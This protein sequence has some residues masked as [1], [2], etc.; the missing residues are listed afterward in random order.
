MCELTL[1]LKAFSP[2]LS[3]TLIRETGIHLFPC[4]TQESPLPHAHSPRIPTSEINS[5]L[6]FRNPIHSIHPSIHPSTY[7]Y[8]KLPMSYFVSFHFISDPRSE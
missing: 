2:L 7:K 3:E 5:N 8:L 1:L 4:H 6:R